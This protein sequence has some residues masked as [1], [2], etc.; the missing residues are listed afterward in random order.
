MD[1]L[2][3]I[4][5]V[6][7]TGIE[8]LLRKADAL[9]SETEVSQTM[10]TVRIADAFPGEAMQILLAQ[11]RAFDKGLILSQRLIDVLILPFVRLG[12]KAM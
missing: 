2:F 11:G 6:T 9:A 3:L 7:C 4:F 1:W 8:A 10:S 12:Q 5:W